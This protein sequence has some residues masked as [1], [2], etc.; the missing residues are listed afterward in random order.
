MTEST[1]L[2][3]FVRTLF[4]SQGKALSDGT[5]SIEMIGTPRFLVV[6][7]YENKDK[8][9]VE[10]KINGDSMGVFREYA[11]QG[12][13]YEFEQRYRTRIRNGR[14][15]AEQ[16]MEDTCA[17]YKDIIHIQKAYHKY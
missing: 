8:D 11:G 2:Y 15:V 1:E 17:F 4:E 14:T 12:Y 10:V 6:R 3:Q 16:Y 13:Q 7:L 9:T 5:I